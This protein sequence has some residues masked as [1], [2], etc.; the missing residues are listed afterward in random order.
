[1]TSRNLR[2]CVG[3]RRN[4][5]P[6]R[7][8]VHHLRQRGDE[9]GRVRQLLPADARPDAKTGRRRRLLLRSRPPSCRRRQVRHFV[10]FN[11]FF[12]LHGI[13]RLRFLVGGHSLL[14]R[15]RGFFN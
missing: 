3:G 2:R 13:L 15:L 7:K 14:L 6:H 11:D 1:M 9:S 10:F 8:R 12:F 5:D 4:I